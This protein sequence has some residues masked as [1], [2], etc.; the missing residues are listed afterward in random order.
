MSFLPATDS[1]DALRQRLQY[2]LDNKTKLHGALGRLEGVTLQIK[3]IQQTERPVLHEPQLVVF[4][5]DQG[6]AARG[7][8]PDEGSGAALAWPLLD[9]AVRLLDEVAT[10]ESAGVS[11][12]SAS[13]AWAV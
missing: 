12:A 13:S 5:A 2:R 6:L 10:F 4:A 7:M 3:V 1:T 8:R 9:S 11:Q